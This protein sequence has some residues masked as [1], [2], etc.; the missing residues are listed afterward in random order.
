MLPESDSAW[1]HSARV[2]LENPTGCERQKDRSA[3]T[4]GSG[5]PINS[6]LGVLTFP[7]QTLFYSKYPFQL[8]DAASL[9]VQLWLDLDWIGA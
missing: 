1:S 8:T 5:P 2:A 4:S 9:F 3:L 7:F 6:T